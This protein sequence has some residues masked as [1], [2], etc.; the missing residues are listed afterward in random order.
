LLIFVIKSN[1]EDD[2]TP[3]LILE[4]GSLVHSAGFHKEMSAQLLLSGFTKILR[5]MCMAHFSGN[6]LSRA[7]SPEKKLLPS[8]TSPVAKLTLM[9]FLRLNCSLKLPNPP[10]S[11][12]TLTLHRGHLLNPDFCEQKPSL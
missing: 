12:N 8:C 1:T 2:I 9:C 10:L 5:V 4:P 6:Y 7:D 3:S 11:L